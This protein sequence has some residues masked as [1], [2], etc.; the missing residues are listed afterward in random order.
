MKPIKTII[1]SAIL[2][3]STTTMSYAFDNGVNPTY[4]APK[5]NRAPKIDGVVD[6]KLW[7]SAPWRDVAYTIIDSASAGDPAPEDISGRYKVVWTHSA[8]YLL[9][10][11]SDDRLSDDYPNPFDNWWNEDTLEIFI[12]EDN[13]G[14]YHGWEPVAGDPMAEHNAYAYHIGLDNQALDIGPNADLEVGP[15]MYP[16]HITARWKRDNDSHKIIWEVKIKVFDDTYLPGMN[17]AQLAMSRQWLHA[18]KTLGFMVSLIDADGTDLDNNGGQ[19]RE[20]FLGDVDV[21]VWQEADG[22]FPMPDWM[23]KNRG[24]V[25]ASVFGNLKLV[26]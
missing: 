20:Y 14:G 11:I 2:A 1:T 24:W 21:P 8:I 23:G 16:E 3:C 18:G 17:P 9:A 12:D 4:E 19:D 22:G 5:V 13:S 10:E 25:D 26:R 7:D 6:N 15:Q